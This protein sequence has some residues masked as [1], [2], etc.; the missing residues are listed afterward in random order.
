M[1][2][3]LSLRQYRLGMKLAVSCFSSEFTIY[4]KLLCYICRAISCVKN[5]SLAYTLCPKKRPPFIF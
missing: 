2:S 3:L 4:R 1:M 5:L